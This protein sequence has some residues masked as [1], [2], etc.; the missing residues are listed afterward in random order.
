[1]TDDQLL[2]SKKTA[3]L[4]DCTEAALALWRR[5]R[6]GPDF[7]RMGRLVRYRKGDVMRWIEAQTVKPNTESAK[8]DAA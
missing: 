7:V 1:M 5:L 4:L 8:K 2:D 3:Q 6:Y